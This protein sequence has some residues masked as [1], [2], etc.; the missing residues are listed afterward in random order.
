MDTAFN[1]RDFYILNY[2]FPEF[3]E[4]SCTAA[5][6]SLVVPVLLSLFPPLS[7][8]PPQSSS[9]TSK[10]KCAIEVTHIWP[11]CDNAFCAQTRLTVDCHCPFV[12]I[13][14]PTWRA[15]LKPA[16]AHRSGVEVQKVV[17]T[18]K[19]SSQILSFLWSPIEMISI[20]AF[21]VSNPLQRFGIL[22]RHVLS[23]L[24]WH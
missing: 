2:Q 23:S 9:V 8:T 17:G 21:T 20:F 18:W 13:S 1:S 12:S 15:V 5:A 16:V 22:V 7:R 6:G 19:M 3:E 24:W 10:W 14:N 11:T 4:T